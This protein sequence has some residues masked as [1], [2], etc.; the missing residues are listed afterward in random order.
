M[1]AILPSCHDSRLVIR[2]AIAGGLK[3]PVDLVATTIYM[4][5]TAKFFSHNSVHLDGKSHIDNLC[6]AN[7]ADWSI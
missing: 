4:V 7:L 6:I 2:M 5:Q 1:S 3:L